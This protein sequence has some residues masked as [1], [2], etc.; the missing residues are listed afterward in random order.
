MF[1]LLFFSVFFVCFLILFFF[2][3]A[4]L[5]SKEKERKEACNW[6]GKEVGR[7]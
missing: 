7:I 2:F 3:F 5:F 4:F 1:L 6:I